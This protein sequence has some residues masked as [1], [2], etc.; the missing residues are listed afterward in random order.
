MRSAD[1]SVRYWLAGF[2]CLIIRVAVAVQAS[3]VVSMAMP[4]VDLYPAQR[5]IT[6]NLRP[7]IPEAGHN[8][9]RRLREEVLLHVCIDPGR[10]KG[11]EAQAP[12]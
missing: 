11:R 1:M 9:Y 6:V 5:Y 8:R 7:G 12:D 2:P 3:P 10:R 4:C